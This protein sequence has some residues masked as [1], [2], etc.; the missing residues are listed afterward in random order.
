MYEFIQTNNTPV[1]GQYDIIDII[2]VA[3]NMRLIHKLH[4]FIINPA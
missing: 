3:M 1:Y 2:H 4:L